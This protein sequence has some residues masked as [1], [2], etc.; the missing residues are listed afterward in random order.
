MLSGKST[1]RRHA[2]EAKILNGLLGDSVLVSRADTP[3]LVRTDEL[4][5]FGS[6]D[7]QDLSQLLHSQKYGQFFI[8]R[9]HCFHLITDL[10]AGDRIAFSGAFFMI[11]LSGERIPEPAHGSKRLKRIVLKACEYNPKDR[12]QT[13]EEMLNELILLT[14]A[15]KELPRVPQKPQEGVF[16]GPKNTLRGNDSF[17]GNEKIGLPA[18][19]DDQTKGPSLPKMKSPGMSEK[20]LDN[21]QTESDGFGEETVGPV[22]PVP[23]QKPKA[24][25][26]GQYLSGQS[27]LLW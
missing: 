5:G 27:L 22:K 23:K 1:E 21:P 19:Y 3:D 12:Y 7:L 10:P 16:L 9:I 4:I 25:K 17:P 20:G 26:G 14:T 8:R 6:A 13:A 2:L 18:E 24:K 11:A 15:K